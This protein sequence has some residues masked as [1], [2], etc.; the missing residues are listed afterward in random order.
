MQGCLRSWRLKDKT[1]ER[2][3]PRWGGPRYGSKFFSSGTWAE[4]PRSPTQSNSQGKRAQQIFQSWPVLEK[5]ISSSNPSKLYGLKL[6][7]CC[8]LIKAHL[9]VRQIR[10]T[11]ALTETKEIKITHGHCIWLAKDNFILNLMCKEIRVHSKP[12]RLVK[13]RAKS[14]EAKKQKD[15]NRCPGVSDNKLIWQG[16][17]NRYE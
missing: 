10:Y 1:Q 4:T 11:P 6:C 3:E 8:K 5:Q 9:R 13:N 12:I 17:K 16:F 2:R 15:W 14:P 7:L